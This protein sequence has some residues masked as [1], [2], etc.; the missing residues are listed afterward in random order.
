LII[1]GYCFTAAFFPEWD[2]RWGAQR[3]RPLNQRV[4][5]SPAGRFGFGIMATCFGGLFLIGDHSPIAFRVLAAIFLITFVAMFFIA[6]RDN[7]SY[8]R[9]ELV[10]TGSEKA[11]AVVPLV[12]LLPLFLLLLHYVHLWIARG[13]YTAGGF[14]IRRSDHPLRFWAGIAFVFA[15]F[16]CVTSAAAFNA[17]KYLR[18]PTSNGFDDHDQLRR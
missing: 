10:A 7:R 18:A 12:F 17:L 3:G 2:L 11:G 13:A 5:L 14:L 9:P 16:A 1:G 8:A 6:R 4:P 15:F